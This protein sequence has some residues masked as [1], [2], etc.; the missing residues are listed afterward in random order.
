MPRFVH[1]FAFLIVL[2]ATQICAAQLASG[3]RV[4]LDGK[5]IRSIAESHDTQYVQT[6]LMLEDADGR[7]YR[8]V[9]ATDS[10]DMYRT[11]D[12]VRVSGTLLTS[13]DEIPEIL[14]DTIQHT[15]IGIAAYNNQIGSKKILILRVNFTDS[16][17]SCTTGE[18]AGLM[19]TGTK[20]I[21]GLYQASSWGQLSFPQDNNADG[22]PDVV[23]VNINLSIGTTCSASNYSAWA[24]AAKNA[25]TAL[26]YTLS[27]YNGVVYVL[28]D[29]VP[30]GW[31]GLGYVGCFYPGGLCQ[32]WIKTCE[33]ADVYAHELGHNLGMMHAAIDADDNGAVDASCGGYSCEYNDQSCIMGYGGVGWRH[34]NTYHKLESGWLPDERV[35]NVSSSGT[36]SMLSADANP[37]SGSPSTTRQLAIVNVPGDSKVYYVSYRTQAD[38]YSSN[39]SGTYAGKIQIHR[40]DSS[41]GNSLLVANL[42]QG[43]SY[44]GRGSVVVTAQAISG[45]EATIQIAY[46]QSVSPTATPTA[47]PP[48]PTVIPTIQPT[49]IPQPTLAPP[50]LDPDEPNDDDDGTEEDTESPIVTFKLSGKRLTIRVTDNV[51]VSNVALN[52]NG[53][54]LRYSRPI[55]SVTKSLAS[56]TT[57]VSVV[58]NDANANS[59][60]AKRTF[61]IKATRKRR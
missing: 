52:I 6:T 33:L 41:T 24:Q 40:V 56:G 17:P 5:L 26:G 58:A 21:N 12:K 53:R 59:T 57:K 61:R 7:L 55:L 29:N 37:A 31:A 42:T 11:G 22:N 60:Q 39:L 9:V 48:T 54:R 14:V 1:Y 19:W 36:F 44:S 8:L 43:Q 34:F 30:C 46:D 20:N 45:S 38:G 18:I 50:D 27:N 32:S 2:L 15:G 13:Q 10:Q 49:R 3:A 16:S 51:A 47:V 23:D 25:A 35:T 28:P 4:E